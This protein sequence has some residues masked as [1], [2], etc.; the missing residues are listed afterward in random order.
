MEVEIVHF[1]DWH[2]KLMINNTNVAAITT[3]TTAI[4]TATATTTGAPP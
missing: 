4:T 2:L 3:I 1:G